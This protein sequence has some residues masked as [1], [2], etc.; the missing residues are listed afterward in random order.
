MYRMDQSKWTA[1]FAPKDLSHELERELLFFNQTI[2]NKVG[3]VFIVK[4]TAV[5]MAWSEWTWRDCNLVRIQ[6]IREAAEYLKKQT[7]FWFAQNVVEIR[8]QTLIAESV[9]LL[10]HKPMHFLETAALPPFGGFALLDRHT[11]LVSQS[12]EPALAHG[13]FTF[14]ESKEAPSRAYLKLWEAL[15]RLGKF[16]K[17]G[18]VCVDLGSAPGGWTWALAK[19]GTTVTSVDRSPLDPQVA[20]MPGVHWVRG[21]AFSQTPERLG[22][23]D[24]LFSDVICFPEKL[25][26]FVSLWNSSG[27]CRNFVCTIKFQGE[28]DPRWIERFRGLGGQVLH[29]F[30]NKHELTWL[31]SKES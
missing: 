3:D 25:Y 10:R 8:R 22:E 17:P 1:Y 29:L 30:H 26:E 27:N 11:M 19:L 2:Q 21:D 31:F 9:S 20:A 5:A 12:L 13:R 7:R 23:I 6:S 18:E 15:H 16:P 4:H 24:W 28:A 14:L